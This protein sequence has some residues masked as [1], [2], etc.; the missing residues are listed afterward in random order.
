MDSDIQFGFTGC[1]TKEHVYSHVVRI[2]NSHQ[3]P[4]DYY[5]Y[6]SPEILRPYSWQFTGNCGCLMHY[7]EERFNSS[8]TG[9][10]IILNPDLKKIKEMAG[11]SIEIVP[12][13]E[14]TLVFK[15]WIEKT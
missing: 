2:P 3:P 15:Y 12:L 9:I 1:G 8:K 11:C 13:G 4:E 6:Q 7:T 5:Q 10:D 14:N